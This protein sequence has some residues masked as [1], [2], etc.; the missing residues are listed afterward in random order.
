MKLTILIV[1][2]IKQLIIPFLNDNSPTKSNKVVIKNVRGSK[3]RHVRI[4][5]N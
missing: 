2:I 3:F 1:I 5:I 4:L